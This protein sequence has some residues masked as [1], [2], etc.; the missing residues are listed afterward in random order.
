MTRHPCEIWEETWRSSPLE[1]APGRGRCCQKEHHQITPP[2]P[3][4]SF[5]FRNGPQFYLSFWR[6]LKALQPQVVVLRQVHSHH[7]GGTSQAQPH[8]HHLTP[9]QS[10]SS[11]DAG[12]VRDRDQELGSG[13]A[14]ER[15]QKTVLGGVVLCVDFVILVRGL[16]VVVF[17]M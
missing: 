13:S 4:S 9:R 15:R 7:Q 10:R 16:G 5:C 3:P 17:P 1:N 11:T 2:L 6:C 8:R 14:R 12:N